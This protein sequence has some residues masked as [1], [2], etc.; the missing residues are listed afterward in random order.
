M[1][2]G[3]FFLALLAGIIL[4]AILFVN[5][6]AS[7][8]AQ[9]EKLYGPPS[10]RL[11]TFQRFSLSYQLVRDRSVLLEPTDLNWPELVF[12]IALDE[13][14]AS[15]LSGLEAGG[16]IPDEGALRN[17]LVYTGLDTQLQAGDFYV[18]PAMTPVDIVHAMLDPTPRY[19]TFVILPGWRIE[20]IAESIPTTGLSFSPGEF[21]TAATKRP[22]YA[23]FN[24][25]LPLGVSLEGF[26]LP[27]SYEVLRDSSADDL[28]DIVLAQFDAQISLDLRDGF[29]R[30]GLSL[31][32]AVTLASIVER[33]A[34]IPEEMPLIASVFLNRLAIDMK[35]ET[36]P[37]VQYALGYNPSQGTWW[38]NPLSL[39]DLEV[40][41]PYN[42]YLY[43]GLPP[44][45]I[46]NP[47]IAALQAVAFPV[48]TP[49]YYFRAACDGSGRHNFAY[50]F[51]EHIANACP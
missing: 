6:I 10:P 41:S 45:P 33:E 4:A 28:V 14:V 49:Y 48:E 13:S 23:P 50:T 22:T 46:A 7:Y 2:S 35:L 24:E 8:P 9:A 30:R 19:V 25:V 44:N 51:E 1:L 32:Q 5:A 39:F 47:S 34:V 20:Q 40:A 26:F 17:Y 37:T 16:L 11:S 21:L 27:G 43:T 31:Y 38:T 3:L 12:S 18:S 29:T 36:D 15:I 42:T